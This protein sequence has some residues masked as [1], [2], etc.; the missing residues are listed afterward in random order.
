MHFLHLPLFY[1]ILNVFCTDQ[2]LDYPLASQA[3]TKNCITADSVKTNTI[4]PAAASTL[5]Q[6]HDGG[7]TWQD[8]SQ[9]LPENEQPQ[10]IFAGE[11]EVYLKVKNVMYRSQSNLRTPVW[12]KE[13]VPVQESTSITFNPSGVMAYNYDG[14]IYQKNT[15]AGTWLPVYTNFKQ[16]LMRTILESSDGTLFVGSDFGLYKSSDKGK[17]WKQIQ[18]EGW[19]MDMVEA[20]GVLIA[21]GQKGIMRSIDKGEH[22]E[23]VISEGGVGIAVERIDGGFAAISY[24]TRSESRRIRISLDGGKNW[25]AIDDGLRPSSSISSIKQMGP[26]LIVGHPDG[27]FHSADKGKTWNLVHPSANKVEFKFI[28]VLNTA[29]SDA[30]KKVFKIYASG[31]TLYAVSGNSGC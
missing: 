24:N 6:S 3:K 7:Q 28:S 11:S 5:L 12:E 4:D 22:W 9:G 31:K 23:W 1:F 21:A 16:H 29:P 10:G 19:T 18:N 30:G 13:N 8:I 15:S 2:A 14:R 25:K 20:N 17:S 26:Y 27:I